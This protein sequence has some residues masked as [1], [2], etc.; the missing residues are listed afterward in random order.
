[1]LQYCRRAITNFLTCS[2][3]DAKCPMV[4]CTLCDTSWIVCR[5]SLIDFFS[6][7]LSS[8]SSSS[9]ANSY[10]LSFD[11]ADVPVI[12]RINQFLKWKYFGVNYV[13]YESL[14]MAKLSG[15]ERRE[16]AIF[17]RRQNSTWMLLAYWAISQV[18]IYSF[19][20]DFVFFFLGHPTKTMDT[21]L[22]E[23]D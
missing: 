9:L 21:L 12:Q 10:S 8:S 7:S 18:L 16:W 2:P 23:T 22:Q 20:F 1:M 15:R 19:E 3:S 5:R 6:W 4:F 13:I 17:L 11:W 14:K